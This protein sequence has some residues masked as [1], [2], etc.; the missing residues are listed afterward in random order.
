MSTSE[1]NEEKTQEEI[2]LYEETK[3]KKRYQ[4]AKQIEKWQ[5]EI[6]KIK[7]KLDNDE[8]LSDDVRESL[9]SQ[10]KEYKGF[11]FEAKHPILAMVGQFFSSLSGLSNQVYKGENGGDGYTDEDLERVH[12]VRVEDGIVGEARERAEIEE[13]IERERD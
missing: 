5:E 7:E 13:R 10:I 12:Q 8:S 4:K 2:T 9:K 11:I 3:T 1:N 6:N